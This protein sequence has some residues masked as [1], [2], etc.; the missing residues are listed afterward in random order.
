MTA[1]ITAATSQLKIEDL[2]R[3]KMEPQ[4][5]WLEG[6]VSIRVDRDSEEATDSRRARLAEGFTIET[7]RLDFNL[8]HGE[9]R[10]ALPVR[11]YGDLFDIHGVGLNLVWNRQ[12][13]RLDVL[14]IDHGEHML[15]W[16]EG[17]LAGGLRDT[18]ADSPKPAASAPTTQPIAEDRRKKN[19]PATTYLVK[20]EGGVSV[21]HIFDEQRIGRL[22]ANELE[23][24]FDLGGGRGE[25]KRAA[26]P[27]GEEPTAAKTEPP[28]RPRQRIEL[29][30]NGRLAL[31]PLPNERP[32]ALPRRHI[33]AFGPNVILEKDDRRITVGRFE[34]H[35]ETQRLWLSPAPGQRIAIDLGPKLAAEAE[36]I[37]F[38]RKAGLIKLTGDIR[39]RATDPKRDDAMQIRAAHW[40]ELRLNACER[41][42]GGEGLALLDGGD[43]AAALE[44][45]LL[46]GD[47]QIE[48][49][50][51]S[52]EAARLETFFR[53]GESSN[54]LQ[55]RLERAV[56]TGA[57]R[58][59][60]GGRNKWPEWIDYLW[61][62]WQRP[63]SPAAGAWR[64][65]TQRL[66]SGWLGL[67]FQRAADG[68][69]YA[70]RA[71]AVGAVRLIDQGQRL[72][73]GGRTMVA[74]L[75]PGNE[76]QHAVVHGSGGQPA[77]IR[78]ETFDVR[79][80]MITIDP[81][82]ETLDVPGTSHLQ[83]VAARSLRGEQRSQPQTVSVDCTEKLHVDN[84]QNAV[85]LAGNV[86]AVSGEESLRADTV[87]LHMEDAAAPAAE[88]PSAAAAVFG[89][90]R[91]VLADQVRRHIAEKSGRPLKAE[92][93]DPARQPRGFANRGGRLRKEP[94]RLEARNAL[95][96]S[97][98]YASPNDP[99]PAV[100]QSIQAPEMDFDI[101]SRVVRTAGQT[102]LGLIDRRLSSDGSGPVSAAGMPSALISRGP[103]LTHIQCSQSMVYQLGADGPGRRD[104]V[105]FEGN[106]RMQHFAGM[107]LLTLPRA[108]TIFPD[109]AAHPERLAAFKSRFSDLTCERLEGMFEAAGEKQPVPTEF[110]SQPALRLTGLTARGQV[111][112][113]D[114]QGAVV[115]EVEAAQVEFDRASS[116]VRVFG[117]K[118]LDKPASIVQ[119]NKETQRYDVPFRGLEL[120]I[121]LN[122]NTVRT[123]AMSGSSNRN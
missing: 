3:Q 19:A 48:L 41:P 87:T 23:L 109:L 81:I 96:S 75:G 82:A 67:D 32:S 78:T 60:S 59:T 73:A 104:A 46:V 98:T 11:A 20:L 94:Q 12:E 15:L 43:D 111:N 34:Y 28:M 37:Y 42:E 56:A 63:L 61:A 4:F 95:V 18:V 30:W 31:G 72:G 100:H 40:A 113:R 114:E 44:S 39:M 27:R 77:R 105:L 22:E 92:E 51:Q 57:V 1:T 6:R 110:R 53:A 99:Q 52:L 35:D 54:S 7:E 90:T 29:H 9:L 17:G 25:G 24:T 108:E 102:I 36:S 118:D 38:D 107:E 50:G 74:D 14:T 115:R 21:D 80:E 103:S 106:V 65:R 123:G 91:R 49:Q 66:E 10:T 33:A 89:Q 112:L 26:T 8:E 69:V 85:Q 86:I 79:G 64:R 71:D 76:L 2:R 70:S 88:A 122:A 119:K 117:W 16:L 68:A 62:K 83:F 116:I 55:D 58:L 93:P 101:R 120:S 13:N 97:E 5:G 84:R 47:V 121:D 45:A